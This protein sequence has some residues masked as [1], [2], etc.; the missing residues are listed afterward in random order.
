MPPKSPVVG[1]KNKARPSRG[2]SSRAS[3]GSRRESAKR[4]GAPGPAPKRTKRYKPGTVALRE[5]RKYQKTT[6]LLLLKLPFQRLVR[7]IA[8]SVTG[9][10]GPNR[11]QS[12]ALFALQEATEAFLVNLFHD[13][14]LCAIHAKRVT[15]QQK[16]IQLARR[17]RAAWGAPV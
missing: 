7:E 15:I 5:I 9:E 14:N 12:Q 10:D 3:T 6:D 16:D 11:W 13:A 17:L 2:G 1:R 4:L 8:Q